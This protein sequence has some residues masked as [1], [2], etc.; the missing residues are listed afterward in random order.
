MMAHRITQLNLLLFGYLILSIQ[1]TI[2]LVAQEQ[3]IYGS[4]HGIQVHTYSDDIH[5][6]TIHVWDI[7]IYKISE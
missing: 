1:G 5:D 3:D 2:S 7:A 4:L 6:T